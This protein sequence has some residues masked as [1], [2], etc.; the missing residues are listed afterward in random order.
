MHRLVVS[1]VLLA[2]LPA[3]GAQPRQKRASANELLRVVAPIQH[4]TAAA[5]PFVNVVVRFGTAGNRTVDSSSFRAHLGRTEI[6][7]RFT[8]ILER[9]AVVGMR[10]AVGPPL[11]RTGH[12][13]NR[14]RLAVRTAGEHPRRD[15]DRLRFRAIETPDQP[16]IAQLIGGNDVIAPGIP[17]HFSGLQSTDPD[18][19]ELT[20]HWDFGDGQTS[21]EPAPTHTY[22]GGELVDRTVTLTVSD[23]VLTGSAEGQLFGA[24]ACDA[25]RTAGVMAVE[26]DDTLDFGGVAP[27]A[28]ATRTFTIRNGDASPVSQVRAVLRVNGDAFSVDPEE[29][30]LDGGQS[31]AITVR[32]APTAAGHQMATVTTVACASKTPLVHLLAHG[33]GGD[34]PDSGPTLAETPLFYVD[35]RNQPNAILPNGTRVAI[36]NTVHLCLAD[37]GTGSRDLCLTNADCSVRGEHCIPT[38]QGRFDP[39]D[40]CSDGLGHL[41]FLSDDIFT[42]LTT[43]DTEKTVGILDLS[44]N[45]Q[46]VRTDSEMLR[47]TTSDT[48][49]LACDRVPGG[50]LYIAEFRNWSPAPSCFRDAREVLTAVNR[51][52]GNPDVLASRIDAVEGYDECSE[53]VDQATDLEVSPDG[54]AVYATLDGGFDTGGAYR[55]WPTPLWISP[56]IRDYFQVHPDG[57]LLYL[58]I[59]NTGETA[60]LSLYKIAP[61]QAVHGAVRLEDI[62]P[63]ATFSVPTNG[64]YVTMDPDGGSFAVA[65]VAGGFDAT[66][67]ATFIDRGGALATQPKLNVKGTIAVSVPAGSNACSVLGLTS[68]DFFLYPRF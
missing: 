17:M 42:D 28:S 45:A 44:L 63:C 3:L 61:E 37:T 47:R 62:S 39:V 1:A 15:I 54:S 25:D 8:P 64:G 24:P 49:Q 29:V 21:D 22:A 56:D 66:V 34:A 5:H 10:G 41:Y 2:A 40:M 60:V 6:T 14:L 19:D 13:A 58:T 55:V 12:R 46:G 11:L 38:A 53:D 20:Y 50:N 57:S 68:L 33:Y 35:F 51:R 67:V 7:D 32:F 30:R 31:Q 27:G 4:G 9:G 65:P 48:A 26:G 59:A 23:G 43:G 18:G 16:P 36:D 52:N